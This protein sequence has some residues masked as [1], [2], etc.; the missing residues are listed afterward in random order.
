MGLIWKVLPKDTFA[1]D[2]FKI[3]QQLAGMPTKA[4]AYTKQLL[5]AS[6]SNSF[7]EQIALEGEFQI[8]AGKTE[9]YTE[10]VTAFVEKRKPAYKGR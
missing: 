9:D 5:N 1:E 8:L 6:F 7:E 3:A 2:G 10:G 4:F